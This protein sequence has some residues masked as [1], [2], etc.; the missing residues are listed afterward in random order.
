[1][2]SFGY[3]SIFVMQMMFSMNMVTTKVVG[4]FLI[5]LVLKFH[6]HRPDSLGTMKLPNALSWFAI[7]TVLNDDAFQLS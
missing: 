3:A 6:D 2:Y 7:C 4:T 1:M 5:L